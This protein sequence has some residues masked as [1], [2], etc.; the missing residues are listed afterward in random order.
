MTSH[1]GEPFNLLHLDLPMFSTSYFS[2]FI[3]L[4]LSSSIQIA[5][6]LELKNEEEKTV[7]VEAKDRENDI[8]THR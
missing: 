3:S 1:Y 7:P 2:S 4:S 5:H 6:V 8:M